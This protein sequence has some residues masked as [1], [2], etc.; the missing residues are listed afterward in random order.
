MTNS[1]QI[2][3]NRP[4][5]STVAVIGAGIIGI[6]CA[7]AL[8]EQGYQVTLFDKSGIGEECSKGNAGHFATEQV[9][10][11]SDPALFWQLPKMLIDP[12]GPISLSPKYFVKAIPWFA[13][14]MLN[15]RSRPYQENTKALQALNQHA[16]DCYKDVLK[17]A[18]CEYL[19]T[20]KGSLLVFESTDI[21]EIKKI[22][23]HY[24]DAGIS[25]TL[26]NKVQAMSLEP[27]LNSNITHALYFTDVAHTINPHQLCFALAEYANQ[28]GAK[29]LR[30]DISD[31]KQD[32][33]SVS[34]TANDEIQVFDKAVIA[35][36][37]WSK[38]LMKRLGYKLPIEAER[39]YHYELSAHQDLNRP[40]ASAERKFIITPMEHSLR[41]AGTVEYAG[42]TGKP[43]YQRAV[44][45][46]EHAKHVLK[47]LPKEQKGA[48]NIQ[49]M[50]PRPSTPDSLPVICQ[51]P[52]HKNIFVAAG[53]QHLGLTQGAITGKLIAQLISK[54][55][56]D[57]D[58]KPFCLSRFN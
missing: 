12:L 58:V 34:I 43:N 45:L 46:K 4:N 44:M 8:Q 3:K 50:G 5:T 42:L 39:G 26:L 11:L 32:N 17:K 27:A 1:N 31:I 14:F 49:W 38:S 30:A 24:L 51:A 29:F 28:L 21:T 48:E 52:K 35:T 9:F 25:V 54:Q 36:G 10:P 47:K 22:H 20:C 7:L 33:D 41:L 16:I 2:D 23:Q 40:V 6:N 56:T 57:I 53:H 19:I 15:M 55:P 37:A 18:Q 13:K